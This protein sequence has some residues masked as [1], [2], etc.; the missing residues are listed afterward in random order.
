MLA[1]S[2][3]VTVSHG[4]QSSDILAPIETLFLVGFSLNKG[5]L[6][7]EAVF[8]VPAGAGERLAQ[9][10]HGQGTGWGPWLTSLS[11]VGPCGS[12]PLRLL[13]CRLGAACL[14]QALQPPL[15]HVLGTG[16]AACR[17]SVARGARTVVCAQSV[18]DG[19]GCHNEAVGY[20]LSG[21]ESGS[22]LRGLSRTCSD[23]PLRT[24]D[25]G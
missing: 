25:P 10:W 1:R 2:C 11:G 24:G 21:N 7:K 18:L 16:L 19:L 20:L 5:Q 15:R 9:G 23:W 14:V 12:A 22:G 3:S 6:A 8:S 17:A 4:W 13:T